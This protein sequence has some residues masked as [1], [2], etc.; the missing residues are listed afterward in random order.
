LFG[1]LIATGIAV[2]AGGYLW[3]S[4]SKRRF[5]LAGFLEATG[6]GAGMMAGVH[7]GI[8]AILPQELVHVFNAAGQPLL[9]PATRFEMD[10]FHRVHLIIGALATVVLACAAM[11]RFWKSDGGHRPF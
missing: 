4:A 6:C 10:M 3:T 8:G 2:G 5:D 1:W 11:I 9:P 7:L